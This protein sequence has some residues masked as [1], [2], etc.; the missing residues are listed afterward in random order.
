M[1]ETE[2]WVVILVTERLNNKIDI[3]QA[4][5]EIKTFIDLNDNGEVNLNELWDTLKGVVIGKLMSNSTAI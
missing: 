5:A 2:S 4:K 1:I 3:Q